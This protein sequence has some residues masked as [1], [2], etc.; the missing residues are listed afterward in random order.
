VLLHGTT[1]PSKRW[2][3]PHWQALA[4][5]LRQR[6][7]RVVLPW[8]SDG[9]RADAQAIASACDGL[10][11]PRLGL[12]ALGGWLAQARACVGVDTG[13][14]HLA[15]AL[16]TPQLTLYG[17]TL[18]QLTGAVGANQMWL[19]SSDAGNIDRQRP[20]TVPVERAQ[21]ALLQAPFD[22]GQP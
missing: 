16:G 21:Q 6:G 19:T 12:T 18:P 10:V 1:W 13:L 15:A 2:P 14:A 4:A 3:L 9:E 20:N 22:L 11:L 8:G 7:L 5:W 17:P